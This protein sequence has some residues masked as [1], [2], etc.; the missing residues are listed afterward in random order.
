MDTHAHAVTG[1]KDRI[2]RRQRR[3][4]R[5]DPR[6]HVRHERLKLFLWQAE[7]H[8]DITATILARERENLLTK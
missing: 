5:E 3:L 2:P 4:P 1:G 8:A 6:R 7:R